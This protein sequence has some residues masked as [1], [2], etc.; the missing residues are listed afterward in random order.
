MKSPIQS[1]ILLTV[2]VIA[3]VIGY[4]LPHFDSYIVCYIGLGIAAVGVALGIILPWE[5]IVD[6]LAK[7]AS[8]SR[9][10]AAYSLIVFGLIIAVS[11]ISFSYGGNDKV[12]RARGDL[13][14][15]TTA[16]RTY[17]LKSGTY[18]QSLD[19]VLQY[20]TGGEPSCL[21]D[22]WGRRYDYDP[23]GPR[24]GGKYPDIWTVA[25]NGVLICN[26]MWPE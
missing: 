20:I 13:Q 22:P 24:N 1:V 3:A 9:R 11:G 8:P 15:L 12:D 25:P 2:A 18:P 23:N 16:V 21:L 10:V 7:L 6:A 17:K 4:L 26:W 19:G 14:T 5:K